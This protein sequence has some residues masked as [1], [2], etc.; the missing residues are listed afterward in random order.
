MERKEVKKM[1][2]RTLLPSL[3]LGLYAGTA[4]ADPAT[5]RFDQRQENQ[6][7]RI[8]QG[9]ESGALNQREAARLDAQQDRLQRGEDRAKADGVVTGRERARLHHRQDH[10]SGNVYRKKHNRR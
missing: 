7:Q 8:D 1:L 10:A 3:L 5:P 9:V 2:L 6:Q 4:L